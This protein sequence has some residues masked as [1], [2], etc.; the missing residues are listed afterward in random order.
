MRVYLA[1]RYQEHP[2]MRQWRDLLAGHGIAVT[3]RWIEGQHEI[4]A[5]ADSDAQRARFA[6][7]DLQDVR[8]ASWLVMY[9]PR[10]HFRTGRGGRHVEVGVALALR[11]PIILVGERENVFHYLIEHVVPSIEAAVPIICGAPQAV[12]R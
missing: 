1:A 6:L 9:S 8:A 3:S 7:E 2:T 11:I 4:T 12:P 10:D 5:D